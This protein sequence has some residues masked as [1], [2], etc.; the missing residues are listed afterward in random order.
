[1][2]MTSCPSTSARKAGSAAHARSKATLGRYLA[3]GLGA[4]G[5]A[6]V[7]C[8]AAVVNIDVTS[9]GLTTGANAGVP[10]G[11]NTVV[12][13]FLG[14]T[15]RQFDVCNALSVS[16]GY[17]PNVYRGFRPGAGTRFATGYTST[18]PTKFLDGSSV[19]SSA[20]F[21]AN[22]AGNSPFYLRDAST[23]R[24]N[25]FTLTPA[26]FIGFR[27]AANGTGPL[28]NDA[29]QFHYG[30]FKVTWD[31]QSDEF[32]VLSG[33]YESTVNAPITVP[34]PTA[35]ALS[36][37]GALALGAGAIRRSRKAR[38]AAAE[39]TPVEAA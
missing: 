20:T 17:Y 24:A 25:N 5:L 35:A 9:L 30:Y 27:V 38:R 13:N 31:R 21:L 10:S 39:E 23:Y 32:R 18:S 14:L 22:G 8:E 15:G 2:T 16:G 19:G 36:G 7:D 33:A 29:T 37:I 6:S 3:T 1:M 34:E 12:N 26:N 11:G 28:F 4:T